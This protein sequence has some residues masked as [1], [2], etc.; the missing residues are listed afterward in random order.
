MSETEPEPEQ[1]P[2]PEQ[3]PEPERAPDATS[4]ADAPVTPGRSWR[5]WVIGVAVAI[6]IAA[7]APILG[8]AWRRYRVR[9]DVMR[10]LHERDASRMMIAAHRLYQADIE[11]LRPYWAPFCRGLGRHAGR[12]RARGVMVASQW[13]IPKLLGRVALHDIDLARI[14]RA[15]PG[16]EPYVFRALV[17]V[18]MAEEACPEVREDKLDRGD[19]VD[20]LALLSLVVLDS[21]GSFDGQIVWVGFPDAPN[22]F[23][24]L[25][26]VPVDEARV[27]P[28]DDQAWTAA[29]S[30]LNGGKI[31]PFSA[32]TCVA[33]F[34][35]D[36]D[37]EAF[38][39]LRVVEETPF[40]IHVRWRVLETRPPPRD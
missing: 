15:E 33:R 23:V 20:D 35:V 28:L 37:T 27:P 6:L 40:K 24:V 14:A 18:G 8:P 29:Q 12:L 31:I 38:V 30:P 13:E 39:A 7:S 4:T 26:D 11:D 5:P 19:V 21:A 9:R 1:Q 10:L 2:E 3:K 16:L 32:G 17:Q 22:V 36:E 34:L 25:G